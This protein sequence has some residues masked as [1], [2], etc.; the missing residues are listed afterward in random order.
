MTSRI[1]HKRSSV[2]GA[3][4]DPSSLVVGEIAI[5]FPDR[6]IYT[7]NGANA[8]LR[9]SG[10]VPLAQPVD[11]KPGDTYL[12]P[13]TGKLYAYYDQGGGNEWFEIAPPEDLSPYV[14]LTGGA[15]TGPLIMFGTA[16][17]NQGI[18]FN[19][20][21]TMLTTEL[22]Q[23]MKVDGSVAMTGPLTLVATPPT[24]DLH[25][26]SKDYVDAA[27]SI[28]TPDLSGYLSLA[29]G[30]M[31][32]HI[33][34]PGGATGNQAASAAD[35]AASMS[36]HLASS[37]PHPQYLN[38][39]ELTEHI[40]TGASEHPL[41]TATVHGFMSSTDKTKLDGLVPAS[42]AEIEAGTDNE[43]YV[44]PAGLGHFTDTAIFTT[45]REKLTENRTYY[46]RTDGNDANNGL[47]D[48]AG[49]AFLTW[50]K[51]VDVA[52]ALDFNGGQVVI[53]CAQ[54][55]ATFTVGAVIPPLIGVTGAGNLVLQG[56]TSLPSA[57]VIN[58]TGTHCFKA[59]GGACRVEGFTF[60][61]A[62][63]GNAAALWAEKHGRIEQRSNVFGASTGSSTAHMMATVHGQVDTIGDYAISGGVDTH[64]KASEL[65]YINCLSHTLTISGTPAFAPFASATL[66][67][68][69]DYAQGAIFTGTA[70]GSRYTSQ[71]NSAILVPAPG[72][73]TFFPGNA[74]GSTSTNGVYTS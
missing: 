26:A 46:V 44:S 42:A 71:S 62:G 33:N 28:A 38:V 60:T 21:N 37:N 10:H 14:P 7:K 58:A 52:A 13:E 35:L 45:A 49:G 39:T 12:D 53:R 34:L 36:A 31:T 18:G 25:A 43:K 20:V 9:L 24:A 54:T 64:I 69:I 70:T 63:S 59:S 11:E 22:V 48:T 23:Y 72:S 61:L 66:L 65:G 50:Q 40:E 8:V 56:N 15:M 17:G 74:A 57:I 30:V 3:I 4:P 68:L 2:A 41:V 1:Q 5:N 16:T 19:Q 67:G 27:V 32:G 73:T 55:T 51:A 6:Y 47:T 29:G